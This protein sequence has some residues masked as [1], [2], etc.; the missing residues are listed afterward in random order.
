MCYFIYK[1][2]GR[3]L[4]ISPQ[5]GHPSCRLG[6]DSSDVKARRGWHTL[7]HILILRL[8]GCP[9]LP[10]TM[11]YMSLNREESG[12]SAVPPPPSNPVG[13]PAAPAAMTHAHTCTLKQYRQPRARTGIQALTG[14]HTCT[15]CLNAQL[16]ARVHK[17]ACTTH[18][19]KHTSTHTLTY[20]HTHLHTCK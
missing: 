13:A 4:G 11:F 8:W 16:Q 9:G 18:V 12:S 17:H 15:S 2:C 5:N 1:N 10:K 19:C 6:F 7:N 20:T 3:F 14:T